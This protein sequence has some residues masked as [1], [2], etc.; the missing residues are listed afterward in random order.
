MT[1]NP[2]LLNS[3]DTATVDLDVTADAGTPSAPIEIHFW[4][5]HGLADPGTTTMRNPRLVYEVSEDGGATWL[6][7]GHPVL[8]RLFARI[9]ITGQD[10]TGDA[11]MAEQ[12]EPPRAIGTNSPILLKDIPPNTARFLSFYIDAPTSALDAN[13]K[14]RLIVDWDSDAAPVARRAGLV[15]GGGVI[16]DRLAASGLRRMV[17]GGQL[18]ESAVPDDDVNVA[19]LLANYDGDVLVRLAQTVAL[20]QNDSAAA[21]LA[22]GESYIA[23]I[24]QP[25][26]GA[27]HATKGAKAVVPVAPA[28]PANEVLLGYVTVHYQAGPSVIVTADIDSES[29]AYGEL[30]VSAGVGLFVDL[31]AGESLTVNDFEQYPQSQGAIAVPPSGTSWIWMLS[32]GAQD[33]TATDVPPEYGAFPLAKVT[34]DALGVTDVT[35]LRPI[36]DKPLHSYAVEIADLVAPLDTANIVLGVAVLDRE[37]LV[38][39][40][41]ADILDD[42]AGAASGAWVFDVFA[43]DAGAAVRMGDAVPGGAVTLFTSFATSDQRPAIAWNATVLRAAT[44]WHEVR[45]LERG[46]RLVVA[47]AAVPGGAFGTTPEGFVIQLKCRKF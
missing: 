17:E 43:L 9:E 27:A 2:E 3:T 23:V 33:V 6:S 1:A 14:H 41:T 24:S 42:G 39:E 47:L 36:V 45:K 11:A 16:A 28:L 25:A 32:G 18:T 19:P 40:I 21:A 20:N 5:D 29:V 34:T 44:K 37:V 46:T 4:N 15:S 7:S 10:K 12:V 35:D 8:D 30:R 31:A 26:A 13:I 38:D 22:V